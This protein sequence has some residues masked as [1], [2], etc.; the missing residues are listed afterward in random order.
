MKKIISLLIILTVTKSILADDLT[1]TVTNSTTGLN[2]G[3]IDLTLN[4]GVAPY[5]F[6][7]T[8]PNGYSSSL[9]DISGLAPG[10]YCV[11][12]SDL[13]C[14]IA[15]MCVTVEEDI[16]TAIEELPEASLQVFP[17]PFTKEF[18]IVFN[19]PSPGEYHFQIQDENGRLI[20]AEKKW[21]ASG[22][23]SIHFTLGLDISSGRYELTVQNKKE[24]A[25]SRSII[26]IR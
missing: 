17:N 3:A 14:G 6:Q 13:Y 24:G 26:N 8:G 18:S 23:Q 4:A 12:V 22:D 9:E 1:A 19:T 11:T 21:L 5:T 15:S 10:T 20:W 2:N 25:L 16:A 7:W